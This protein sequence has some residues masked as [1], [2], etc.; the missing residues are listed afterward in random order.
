MRRVGRDREE[1]FNILIK[2][3]LSDPPYF[4]SEPEDVVVVAG[5]DI[6]LGC[7]VGGRPHPTITWSRQ[8][9]DIRKENS[10]VK[11]QGLS[12]VSVHPSDA[13]IYVCQATNKAGSISSSA[14]LTVEEP[15]VISVKPGALHRVM[16][17]KTIKLDCFVTGNPSP[18]VFWTREKDGETWYAA[19]KMGNVFMARNH[20]LILQNITMEN[21]G[22][23]V[24]V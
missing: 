9:L 19:K 16:E 15:P 3:F 22:D 23:Y 11:E 8:G 2:T 18:T 14:I 1:K 7:A 17:G 10:A 12:L 5:E 20:T 13:G 21:G 24:C 6:E 4:L